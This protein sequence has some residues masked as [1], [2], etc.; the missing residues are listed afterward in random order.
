LWYACARGDLGNANDS[1]FAAK[2]NG[3][4]FTEYTGNG[5]GSSFYGSLYHCSIIKNVFGFPE[6]YVNLAAS[7]SG[8]YMYKPNGTDFDIVDDLYT[9]SVFDMSPNYI[10]YTATCI[11]IPID[12][13]VVSVISVAKDRFSAY[14][15]LPNNALQS[16]STTI[17]TYG[18]SKY[19]LFDG[20]DFY[21]FV[22]TT[23]VVSIINGVFS[24]TTT[25]VS[26]PSAFGYPTKIGNN[27]YGSKNNIAYKLSQDF[28]SYETLYTFSSTDWIGVDFIEKNGLIYMIPFMLDKTNGTYSQASEYAQIYN[29][30]DGTVTASNDIK[31]GYKMGYGKYYAPEVGKIYDVV[32]GTADSVDTYSALTRAIGNG[33][34]ID[35]DYGDL[36]MCLIANGTNLDCLYTIPSGLYVSPS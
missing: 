19:A 21:F 36:R 25:G 7:S 2:Y 35:N 22:S 32:N 23:R 12:D 29:P 24:D 10:P 11:N 6:L 8:N 30:S 17:F 14:K 28:S 33:D 18:L 9:S 34:V 31:G 3:T 4:N 20:N 5:G 13:G 15:Y 26:F 1:Y 27:I 16:R